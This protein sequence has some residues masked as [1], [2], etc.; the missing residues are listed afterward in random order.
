MTGAV[1]FGGVVEELTDSSLFQTEGGS[2]YSPE[3]LGFFIGNPI[4][5]F[6]ASNN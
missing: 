1:Q 5:P 2:F 6:Q 3:S 4:E